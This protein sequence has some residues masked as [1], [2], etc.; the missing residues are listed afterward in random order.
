MCNKSYVLIIFFILKILILIV[1]PLALVVLYR[2]KNRLF[3]T[4]GIINAILIVVLIVLRLGSN[5]CVI[6]SNMKYINN[7][8]KDN[9]IGDNN[10]LYEEIYS[11]KSYLNK[12]SNN[13]YYYGLNEGS[14]SKD[15]ISCDKKSYMTNYGSSITALTMLM[16]TTFETE[17]NEVEIKN[18]AV[19]NKL[20]DCKNGVDFNKLF[21]SLADQYSFNLYGISA[22]EIDNYLLEGRSVLVETINK[23]DEENN[24]G[25]GKDYIIIYNKNNNDE[26]NILNPND[27]SYS[28]FCPSNTIGYGSI[29]KENQN[30]SNYSFN[31]IN[32]KAV[33]YFVIEVKK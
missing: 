30:E 8:D 16:S 1:L 9:S 20:V 27:K 33:R 2:L 17:F 12:K 7:I 19:N 15:T 3:N 26:Y 11:T 25:C 29:I 18:F 23:Y 6:N 24:F 10:V 22:Y 13:V 14:L 5:D 32:S 28:Y 4:I 21:T 31:D